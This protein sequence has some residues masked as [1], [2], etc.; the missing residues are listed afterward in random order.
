MCVTTA[1]I[2]AVSSAS[3][4]GILAVVAAKL[5][6]KKR[7]EHTPAVAMHPQSSREHNEVSHEE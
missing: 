1:A 6:L 7:A 4:G 5:H 2:V 3:T